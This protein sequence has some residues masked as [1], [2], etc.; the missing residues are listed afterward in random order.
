MVGS[1]ATKCAEEDGLN[2]IEG[3]DEMLVPLNMGAGGAELEANQTGGRMPEQEPNRRSIE[4]RARFDRDRVA[5]RFEGL[6]RSAALQILR[7]ELKELRSHLKPFL[8]DEERALQVDAGFDESIERFY[9]P[10]SRVRA[11]IA[12]RMRSVIE[13]YGS[14]IVEGVAAERGEPVDLAG[15]DEFVAAVTSA[16]VARHVFSS[17]SEIRRATDGLAPGAEMSDALVQLSGVWEEKRA[18]KIA[19][20]EAVQQSRAFARE[21]Y[22][23][24]G[25]QRL[26]WVTRGSETCAMCTSLNGRTVSIEAPFVTEGET[27]H[28]PDGSDQAPVTASRT[29][30]HAPLHPGCDC[31]IVPA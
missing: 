19:R 5:G 9:E 2:P 10:G 14:S 3:L 11:L 21:G 26:V 8:G 30:M 20:A 17:L 22:R 27:F 13:A 7:D 29:I 31:D 6:I 4:R 16:F 12:R 1:R 23:R 24:S 28:P 15:F 18:P 25:V